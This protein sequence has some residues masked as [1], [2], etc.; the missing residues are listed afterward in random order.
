[1]TTIPLDRSAAQQPA[2]P[3]PVTEL[4]RVYAINAIALVALLVAWW[5]ASGTVRNGHQVGSLAVGVAAVVVSG[6]ANAL[7]VLVGRRSVSSRRRQIADA[8]AVLVSELEREG[9]DPAS[10]AVPTTAAFVTLEGVR[11]YHRPSCDLVVGKPIVAWSAQDPKAPWREPC[12]VCR[13]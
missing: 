9:G 7:W 3:W 13:P 1:M 12:G 6:S 11:R 4:L 10:R 8:V 2:L 5:V